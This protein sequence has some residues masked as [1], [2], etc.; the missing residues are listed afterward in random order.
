MHRAACCCVVLIAHCAAFLPPV[1]RRAVRVAPRAAVDDAPVRVDAASRPLGSMENLFAPRRMTSD[2]PDALQPSTAHV[3]VATLDVDAAHASGAALLT[4]ADGATATRALA[5]CVARHPMLSRRL[6]GSGEPDRRSPIGAPLANAPRAVKGTLAPL[7]DDLMRLGT[8]SDPL[9]FEPMVPSDGSAATAEA[10]EV[11][12]AALEVVTVGDASAEGP[13]GGGG[14][15]GALDAAWRAR[16]AHELDRAE[17]DLENGP[18]WRVVLFRDPSN[19]RVAMLFVFNHAISDQRSAHTVLDDF[20]ASAARGAP[21]DELSGSASLPLPRSLEDGIASTQPDAAAWRAPEA[22]LFNAIEAGG[23]R[24][25]SVVDMLRDCSGYIQH[26][27]DEGKADP[28][29]LPDW[30]P[31]LAERASDEAMRDPDARAS[32]LEHRTLPPDVMA[33]LRAEARRRDSTVGAALAAASALATAAAT[34]SARGE[35]DAPR[36]FKLLQSLDMSAFQGDAREAQSSTLGCQAGSMDLVLRACG[37]DA[38]R[39]LVAAAAEAEGASEEG[40]SVA[41]ERDKF[42]ALARE[43]GAQ[44]SELSSAGFVEDAVRVFDW[45]TE[46]MEIPRIVELAAG[47]P[48]TLG[49]AYSCGVSNAGVYGGDARAGAY[50]LSSVRYAVSHAR[51][52]SIF[53]LSCVTVPSDGDA[54]AGSLHCVFAAPSPL[55]PRELLDAYADTCLRALA[56]AAGVDPLTVALSAE[57]STPADEPKARPLR[58]FA[59]NVPQPRGSPE[60]ASES[61]ELSPFVQLAALVGGL[62]LGV[63]PNAGAFADFYSRVQMMQAAGVAGDELSAPLTFWT[64]FA[65]MHPLIGG[66]GVGIGEVMW[67]FPG[68]DGLNTAPYGFLA[69]NAVVIAALSASTTLRTALNSALLGLFAL[70]VG[71][72]LAGNGDLGSYNL[73]LDNDGNGGGAIV[74]CPAYEQVRQPTMDNFDLKKYEGRWFEHAYHDW[75]QFSEVYDTTLDIKLSEDGKRWVDDFAVKGPSPKA[76]PA[77]WRGSPVAN[78]AHYLLY[79]EVTP[80]QPGVLQES[81]FGNVFPNYIVDVQKNEEGEYTEAI[82]FQCL[83]R[84]GVRIFEGINYLTRDREISPERLAAMHQRAKA[85]GLAPYGATPEQMHVVEHTPA[86]FVPLDNWWQRAWTTIGVDKLLAL[87]AADI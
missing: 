54:A 59:L 28:V 43:A 56:A 14:D 35:A 30:A 42:W 6:A 75:T 76:A 83:G 53:Q 5:A 44:L 87:I 73:A 49:R 58:K 12:R 26:K 24:A 8:V 34:T 36:A 50:S 19:S 71:T 32:L 62:A 38:E 33:A 72:G 2:A 3:V 52:G 77:S 13:D 18:L 29:V 85:A 10:L 31:P 15:G 69:L 55:V 79:G 37:G 46:S 1:R 9:R 17:F 25:G 57:A 60:E 23:E 67:R 68:Y 4:E 66:V 41:D 84:G 70:Y 65:A 47:S 82:Q 11:A 45:A 20:L 40:S 39:L 22:G 16:F 86:D 80:N 21:A 74:G 81:G 27:L 7:G 78:G 61:S 51:S 63:A 64:F 48:F